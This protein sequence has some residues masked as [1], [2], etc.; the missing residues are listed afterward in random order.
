MLTHNLFEIK[1][2]GLHP[3][4]LYKVA[5]NAV[6]NG[7]MPDWANDD[8]QLDE[9]SM[10]VTKRQPFADDPRVQVHGKFGVQEVPAKVKTPRHLEEQLREFVDSVLEPHPDED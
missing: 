5:T 6:A 7:L 2:L 3:L 10:A 8:E 9:A 1:F 4:L